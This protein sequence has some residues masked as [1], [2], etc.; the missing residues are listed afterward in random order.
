M[1]ADLP[2]SVLMGAGGFACGM[3]MGGVARGARF[4]TFGAVE[5]WAFSGKLVRM[6][7][8]VLAMAVAMVAVIIAAGLIAWCL[9]DPEFRISARDILADV[10]IGL[11]VAAGFWITGHLGNDPF[12]PQR[13]QSLTYILPPGETIQYLVTFTGATITFA[14]GLT[15]GT[16]A[17]SAAIAATWRE[18]RL[19]AFDDAREMR[20]H[21]AGGLLMG[22]GGVS[23]LRLYH[24]PGHHRHVDPVAQRPSRLRRHSGR[25]PPRHHHPYR[26]VQPIGVCWWPSKSRSMFL[27]DRILL[28]RKAGSRVC[29]TCGGLPGK[30]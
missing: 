22:F 24:R 17:G 11:T 18:M 7:A 10:A 3:V 25:R 13:V 23:A 6:R 2:V 1:F 27:M 5:D 20:R 4:C 14:V 9:R 8:W 16:I 19:E 26:P 15:F 21:L 28:G 30:F 12:T 29:A